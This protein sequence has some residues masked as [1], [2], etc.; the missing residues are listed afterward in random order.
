M[1]AAINSG[2]RFVKILLIYHKRGTNT[3]YNSML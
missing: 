3:Y 1:N 2:A